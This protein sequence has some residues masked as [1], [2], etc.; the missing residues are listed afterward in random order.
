M[1]EP[2]GC[3]EIRPLLPE[4]ALGVSAGTERIAVL[5]H[6]PSCSACAKEVAEL[7]RTA[8][9]LLLLPAPSGPPAGFEAA[10]IA[11]LADGQP[12]RRRSSR[13]R[14]RRL[15]VP[16]VAAVVAAVLAVSLAMWQT[17]DV[18]AA[19][20]RYRRTFTI[21]NGSYLAAAPLLSG[22][23]D[24]AGTLFLYQGKPSWGLLTVT[25]APGDGSYMVTVKERD[26]SLH[27]VG[28]CAV[29]G[30][31]ANCSFPLTGAASVAAVDLAG[32]AG[33]VLTATR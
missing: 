5:R 11:A 9:E 20:E 28:A 31:K 25:S 6:L 29:T 24:R 14:A 15:L 7:S 10:T 32:P 12:V 21:A 30:R 16:A 26:G 17:A 2:A 23:G 1:T 8:D 3:E 27:L 18:R 22:D 13:V 4:F 33:Q 19:G